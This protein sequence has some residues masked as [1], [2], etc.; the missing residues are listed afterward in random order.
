MRV[1]YEFEL[2]EEDRMVIADSHGLGYCTQGEDMRDAVDMAV[3]LVHVIV[4][5][6]LICGHNLPQS[7]IGHA[8]EHGGRMLIVSAECSL[9]DTET[10]TAS[11]AAEILGVSRSRVSHMLRDGVLQGYRKGRDTRVTLDS[12]KTR[13]DRSCA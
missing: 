10:V 6:A 5:D 13:L 12:I 9:D 11:E 2:W 1:E 4:R 8:P 3:D 7:D